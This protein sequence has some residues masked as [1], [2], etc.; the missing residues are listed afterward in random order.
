MPTTELKT[1]LDKA[2][3]VNLDPKRYGTFA[4]IGAGQE[5]VRWF[6][7][8]GAAAG[9][10]SKSISAYDMKVSDAIYGRCKRYVCR[11]RLESMLEYEQD[12]NLERL[13]SERGDTTAFFTFADTVSARNYHG[14]NECHGWMGV[15]FQAHPRDESSQIIIH[16]R[17]LDTTNALQQEALGVVGVNLLYGACMLH[18]H[19]DKLIESLLDN[20]STARIEIDMIE[21]SGIEFRHV[22]NRL[23]SL[24]LVQLG[25]TSAAMFGAKGKVLQPSE[26][27]RKKAVLVERGSFRPVCNT[28]IDIMRCAHERFIVEPEVDADSVIQIMEVTMSN[29][30]ADGQIDYRD[31]L[32]RADMLVACGM[33]VLISDYFQY[34]RLAAYLSR[35]TKKK[36]GITMGIGSVREL[37]DEKYYTALEGGILESFGRLFKNDLKLYVYPLKDANKKELMTIENLE[38]SEDLKNLY[39]YLIDRGC[40]E[41]L[42]NHDEECLEVFSRDVL[43]KIAAGDKSWEKMV[44]EEVAEVIKTRGYFGA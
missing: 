9:T 22:D 4:E 39:N 8:A 41:Q 27:L 25:L 5:V 26:V 11:D 19:P 18:H 42:T 14:T 12:L 10:I 23:M 2:L 17:M 24:K 43:A 32:A 29:L 44:P 37:F 40:I 38:V 16:V 1:T 20:L 3:Q 35:Y 34:Y 36:I 6:F 30:M 31:F 13:K 21:F 33:T 15:R 28:N 7:R